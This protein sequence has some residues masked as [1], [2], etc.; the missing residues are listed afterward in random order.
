MGDNP[1]CRTLFFNRS[2]LLYPLMDLFLQLSESIPHLQI[3]V[4]RNNKDVIH[5][6]VAN[7]R[8]TR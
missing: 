2:P 8:L 1:F 3:T 7:I 6:W 5:T 4:I